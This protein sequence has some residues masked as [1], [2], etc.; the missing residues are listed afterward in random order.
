MLYST[1]CKPW[2]HSHI[3]VPTLYTMR[4]YATIVALITAM[5]IA[6]VAVSARRYDNY[7]E[8]LWAGDPGYLETAKLSDFQF[9]IG[10]RNG[11]G[12][13][14]GYMIM[15]DSDGGTVANTAFTLNEPSAIRRAAAA[16]RN[17][18]RTEKDSYK[19]NI[20]LS[21]DEPIP[22]PAGELSAT[23]SIYDGTLTLT[24]GD[25]VYAFLEKDMAASAAASAAALTAS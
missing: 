17:L 1:R 11:D 19:I 7:L 5:I 25:T 20:V 24:S 2:I 8:G 14:H 9:Y 16:G 23:M 15:V 3:F 22:F 13:R 12:S 18:L 21:T 10:P 4:C 6:A